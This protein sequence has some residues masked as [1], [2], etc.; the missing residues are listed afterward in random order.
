MDA[1]CEV[2][3][4]DPERVVG[5]QAL[6]T[7]EAAPLNDGDALPALWHWVAL[8]RWPDPETTGHDGHPRRPGPLADVAAVRR[9][10]AGGEVTFSDVPLLVGEEVTVETELIS[11][12]PKSG[13]SGDFVLATFASQV[14][15]HAGAVLLTERQHIVYTD[16]RAS[17]GTSQVPGGALPV[18]GRPLSS[19][20]DGSFDL[21]T[22]PTVLMRFSSLT[23]NGHRIHYDL[24]YAR[25][26]EK[27]PGLLVHGPF[28]NLA[29]VQAASA[30]RTGVRVRRITHRNLN[31]LYCGQPARL[32]AHE[33]EPG[34]VLA[35]ATG[36][37]DEATSVKGRV[38]VEYDDTTERT[39]P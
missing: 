24:D 6:L 27:L 8:P 25:E 15:N 12:V 23:A 1:S 37:G 18:V 26:V 11:V 10:F 33:P 16:P 36:P 28:V 17:I 20:A 19:G 21:I 2:V 30:T 3:R 35:E 32:A 22:D 34:V 38:T 31:P 9:M 4:V 14:S 29:L 5:L 39:Q 7:P 13:R